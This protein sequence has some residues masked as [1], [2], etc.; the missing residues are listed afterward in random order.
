VVAAKVQDRVTQRARQLDQAR[1]LQERMRGQIVGDLEGVAIK[2]RSEEILIE[3]QQ[4][5]CQVMPL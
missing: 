1:K 2:V 3:H 4:L 5:A